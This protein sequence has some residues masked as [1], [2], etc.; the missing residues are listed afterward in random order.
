LIYATQLYPCSIS[1]APHLYPQALLP[2]LS[3]GIT[4]INLGMVKLTQ[5]H[6]YIIWNN[7]INTIAK[8]Y[9]NHVDPYIIKKESIEKER[10][11]IDQNICQN[12]RLN[13]KK[14]NLNDSVLRVKLAKRMN[15][16]Y[17]G[18]LAWSNDFLYIFLV[19]NLGTI[20]RNVGL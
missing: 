14:P 17:Y 13:K 16:N 5:P 10:I 20:A 8:L 12:E 15:H 2:F 11:R 3:F 4:Q 1:C 9:A 18:E 6:S 7:N 19:V